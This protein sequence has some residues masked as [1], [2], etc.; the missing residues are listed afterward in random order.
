MR[1]LLPALLLLLALVAA[2]AAAQAHA[3]LVEVAPADGAVMAKAPDEFAITFSEPTA[4]M[5]LA[6][7]R[8]DGSRVPLDRFALHGSTL[9]IAAPAGLG[10]GTY[11][12]SWRV[13]SEDGHPVGGST[14][15][16]IGAPSAGAAAP[17]EAP[18]GPRRVAIWATR[19]ALY[20]GL[21][22]GVGG[23]VFLGWIGAAPAAARALPALLWLGL[24]AAVLSLGL[25]GVDARG[26]P[27][28]GLADAANWAAGLATSLGP[29][30]GL[31]AL[32]LIAARLALAWPGGCR[33]L[34][35][36][37]LLGVGL[38]LAASGH[39]STAP[40]QWLTRPAVFLHAV[41]I[42][43]WAGALL[44]LA[45]ELA[46]GR[47]G[48][49]GL[50]RRFS[51]AIP[52]A[53]LPLVLA[54]LALAAAQLGGLAALATTGY[55]QVALAKLALL[56]PLFALAAFNRQ[57]LTA[58]AMRGDLPAR[59]GLVWSVRAELALVLG[60]FAVVALWRFTPPP[61]A[62]AVAMP[63]AIHLH[64]HTEK[65]MA[66]L[67]LAPG[68]VGPARA[69]IDVEGGDFTPLDA[70]S[71][72]LVLANP[73]AGIEPLHLPATK[74]EDGRWHVSLTLPVPGRWTVRL[75]ILISD[76]DMA[77]LEDEIDV[78]P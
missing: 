22:L 10:R 6:L 69:E 62:L 55:G 77:R 36:I 27:L 18:D 7:L 63:P 31:A 30:M 58:P 29:S 60:L 37:G 65:A 67:T 50:L 78:R 61:R 45:T 56:V 52:F 54:G 25:Q 57:H 15:F 66:D 76:F 4:P 8:P 59:A 72:T 23:V 34:S 64:I 21:F 73:A 38:A 14:T 43:F 49:A 3:A 13:I 40:P 53:V 71:V 74:G 9:A 42:A 24:A 48:A 47:P 33:A 5:V 11:V 28:A 46:Q 39:A 2:P 70:Q 44:P 1:H 26:V 68:H 16:S 51:R 75:D 32:A 19:I 17:A 20:A 12:L 35:A 41:G